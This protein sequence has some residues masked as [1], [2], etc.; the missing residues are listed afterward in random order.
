MQLSLFVCLFNVE[1]FSVILVLRI[2]LRSSCLA[3]VSF[4]HRSILAA[5]TRIV[6]MN[7]LE[8]V[9]CAGTVLNVFHLSAP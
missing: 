8:S 6:L 4:T 7:F 2:E 5:L 9:L 3:A 1:A